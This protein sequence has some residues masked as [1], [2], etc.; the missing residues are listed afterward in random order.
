M[1]QKLNTLNIIKPNVSGLNAQVAINTVETL[2]AI[3][4]GVS[5]G[6]EYYHTTRASGF[7]AIQQ[8]CRRI[9]CPDTFTSSVENEFHAGGGGLSVGFRS[10]E[11]SVGFGSLVSKIERA[12]RLRRPAYEH[13]F[14]HIISQDNP[15]LECWG[16]VKKLRPRFNFIKD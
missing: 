7:S 15:L 2:L 10:L 6:P 11:R 4:N 12:G 13:C 9:I 8:K 16:T 5:D 3:S 14:C 1:T